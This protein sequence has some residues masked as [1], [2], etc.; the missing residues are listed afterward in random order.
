MNCLFV[1]YDNGSYVHDLPT[2]IGYLVS[3]VKKAGHD[4]TIYNQDMHH[5]P[6]VH[7]TEYLDNNK[8]DILGIGV[9]AGYY[10][11]KKLISICKAINASKNRPIIILGGHGPTPD[12]DFFFKKTNADFI[13]L[14][15]GEETIVELLDTIE[16]ELDFHQVK[17]LAFQQD[18]ITIINERRL[19]I[20]DVN[21][22]P[23]PAYDMFPIEYYR[24]IKYP[25]SK[26]N[27][28][29]MPMISGRGCIYRC[30]FCFRLDVGFRP[31][32][33]EKIIEEM[34]Y[35]RDK[36]GV[37]NIYFFDE[38]LMVSKQRTID[39]SNAIKEAN[40]GMTWSC[41][42]RLNFAT[43]DVLQVM[44]DAGCVFINY[45]IEALDNEVLRLMKKG[46][47]VDIIEEGIK[48]TLVVG[49]S[50]GLNIMW[51]NLGDTKETLQKAVDFLIKYDDGIQLRAIR[52]VTP[53]PGCPLYYYAI[54][55]GYIKDCEDFYENKHLN[56]DLLTVNF[57]E[58]TDEEAYKAL[59]EA[60]I[61]LLENYYQNQLWKMIKQT[62]KLYLEK[63]ATFR[64]YRQS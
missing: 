46:L 11:Y 1:I 15:E 58:I 14:G 32:S 59:C 28:F 50:P 63:D 10:Q 33:N 26:K 42:G 35:L 54:E 27:E 51:G 47:T 24:L 56:S 60:N 13:V 64:G 37:T 16:N 12:P 29:C 34:K 8:F 41:N 57:M 4:V 5:Y 18:G 39:L 22:I 20:Q 23:M 7:L 48:N 36:Y 6:D 44:K 52:F 45:G 49:I 38:L 62:R 53:Y 17:G 31:R 21:S 19:P 61:K 30:V 9:I 25:G 40:L 2:G 43:K 55:K 3:V